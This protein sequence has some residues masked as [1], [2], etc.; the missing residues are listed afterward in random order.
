[1]KSL[2]QFMVLGFMIFLRHESF[3]VMYL[4]PE[5]KLENLHQV[6]FRF[7]AVIFLFVNLVR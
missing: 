5:R 1:M 3:M 4:T 6:H 2:V 7:Y